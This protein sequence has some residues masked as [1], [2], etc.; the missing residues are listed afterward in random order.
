L[1]AS[2]SWREHKLSVT[3]NSRRARGDD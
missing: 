2:W 3:D 1:T